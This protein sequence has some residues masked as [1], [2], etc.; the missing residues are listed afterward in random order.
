MANQL[1]NILTG[2]CA[3]NIL[4][5]GDGV[6]TVRYEGIENDYIVEMLK[7]GSEKVTVGEAWDEH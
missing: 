1:N 5:V 2:N 4:F 6:D 7:D 3:N